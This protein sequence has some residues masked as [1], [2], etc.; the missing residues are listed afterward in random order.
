MKYGLCVDAAFRSSA[1]IERYTREL[2]RAILRE[3]RAADYLLITSYP[4]RTRTLLHELAGDARRPLPG[5]A[6]SRLSPR[7]LPYAWSFLATPT[8]EQL[9]RQPLALAHNPTTIRI[10]TTAPSIVTVHD[11][12]YSRHFRP[13]NLRQRLALMP[14]REASAIRHSTHLIAD[15]AHTKHDIVA[16][17][18]T[19]PERITVVP[20]G[21]DHARFRPVADPEQTARV[22]HDH[23]IT[24]P[25]ILY[26]GSLYTRKLGLL[27]EAFAA[28]ARKL[29]APPPL[30]VIVGGREG[31]EKGG[32]TLQRRIAQLGIARSVITTGIIPESDLIALMSAAELFVYP[33][34]YEGFGLAPLEAMACGAPI[35]TANTSSLPEVVGDAALLADPRDT[36]AIAAA[37]HQIL[38]TPQL[39]HDLRQRSLRQAQRFSWTRTARETIAVYNTIAQS[40]IHTPR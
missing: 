9:T 40:A 14:Q 18:G 29:A 33:S 36:D 37:L 10:P 22:L 32:L 11:L 5:I 26:A 27:P 2:I 38:T 39:Q 13:R 24:R 34:Y 20:L 15:S 1:G 19:A 8:L 16:T 21:V 6:P 12:Y 17:Y 7:L 35:V 4:R 25:F 31:L 23:G 3:D 28:L 30:L